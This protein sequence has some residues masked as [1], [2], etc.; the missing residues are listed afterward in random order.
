MILGK[1]EEALQICKATL[2]LQL[3]SNSIGDLDGLVEIRFLEGCLSRALGK[4]PDAIESFEQVLKIDPNHV[5]AHDHLYGVTCGLLPYKARDSE[6]DA[7]VQAYR[8]GKYKRIIDATMETL[9]TRWFGDETATV[10]LVSSLACAF[11]SSGLYTIGQRLVNQRP[12]SSVSWYCVGLFYQVT[13]RS[14]EARRY[15]FKAGI[16]S[17]MKK[18][19]AFD[20][21]IGPAWIA[22][23]HSFAAYG[24]HDQ[25]VS[26]YVA[27]VKTHSPGSVD[28]SLF[29]AIE[30]L[31][32]RLPTLSA[33]YLLDAH[34]AN[35]TDPRVLNE[36]ACLQAGK[37]NY[38]AAKKFL[39]RAN[40]FAA[41]SLLPDDFKIPL[42]LNYA[43]V[44]VKLVME[45]GSLSAESVK[46]VLD[47]CVNVLLSPL[48]GSVRKSLTRGN[49]NTP[50][51]LSL[52][53]WTVNSAHPS[54]E[55]LFT[56]TLCALQ[57]WRALL[58]DQPEL[59]A[60]LSEEALTGYRCL[61]ECR[62]E[63]RN[64]AMESVLIERQNRLLCAH[65]TLSPIRAVEQFNERTTTAST[66]TANTMNF[67]TPRTP[68]F[69][70]HSLADSDSF[71]NTTSSST[72]NS[73]LPFTPHLS[74]SGGTLPTTASSI[75]A[76]AS[77]RRLSLRRQMTGLRFDPS[78]SPGSS[79]LESAADAS[80]L[81]TA[82][83]IND[84]L[85]LTVNSNILTDD[86]VRTEPSEEDM[87]LDSE[88]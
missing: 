40:R 73:H 3:Q 28:P 24:D 61:L 8:Q 70:S 86:C 76:S 29:L 81:L 33:A 66:T 69:R 62:N 78:A 14:D 2:K 60:K 13:G 21:G 37:E 15:L 10:L 77:R 82:T 53:P 39:E 54:A 7:L 42:A 49:G 56:F 38:S 30:Y 50:N 87:Q 67:K 85:M 64:V 51:V 74:F 19:G 79:S 25:A 9:W 71:V 18:S 75:V 52:F 1:N 63:H 48:Q 44:S 45:S 16:G 58:C 65:S 68:L 22:L 26:A 84:D 80:F 17:K 34:A 59:S 41:D 43:V 36:L 35:P 27:A 46:S 12:D 32:V 31:R 57:E 83:Q 23:G 55:F 20:V 72:N 6:E 88:D 11:D 4:I 47:W 5:E